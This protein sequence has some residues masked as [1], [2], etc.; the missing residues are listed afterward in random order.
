MSVCA[1]V[2]NDT[3]IV[4]N[5]IMA[6]V[7]EP[8]PQHNCFLVEVTDEMNCAS[9]FW[10]NGTTFENMGSH[11]ETPTQP[12]PPANTIM[13]VMEND[14]KVGFLWDGTKFVRT[15]TQESV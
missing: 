2:D 12:V 5:I 1:V 14:I 8:C 6:E 15:Y 4:Q 9:G 11:P 3:K 13:Y 7:T 10:W